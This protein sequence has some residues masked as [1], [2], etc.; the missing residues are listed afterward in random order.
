[1]QGG[2]STPVD[3]AR[4][5]ARVLTLLANPLHG[6]ILRAHAAG[7]LRAAE[8]K[9]MAGW[10]AQTTLRAANS[11]LRDYGLLARREVSE[12]PYGVATELTP[13]GHEVL[14]VAEVVARWL[15]KAQPPIAL[16][17][18]KAKTAVKSLAGGW[19]TKM[20]RE[21][22]FEPASLTDLDRRIP[23]VSYPSLERRLTRMR[24]TRQV[25]PSPAEGRGTPFEVTEW[26]RHSVP[27]I[28][29]AVRCE[30]RYMPEQS[31]MVTAVEIEAC[32]LLALPLIPL[33]ES[34]DGTCTLSVLP[35]AGENGET[36]PEPAGVDV[37]V[38]AGEIV[39][40]APEVDHR[41]PAYALGTPM[42]WLNA[43]IEGHFEGLRFGGKN[44]QL[45][46]DLVNG[47]HLSLFG[48]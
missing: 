12:M 45:T 8:L 43:V 19:N 32:F 25:T 33:P 27:P 24:D 11:T 20:V 13:A 3:G 31:A 21:L 36:E 23:E 42:A 4:A 37:T 29:A 30:R 28:C 44:P 14:F 9:E 16:D 39:G 17:S 2:A 15:G 40:C 35:E 6:R 10:P 26:L 22:A 34:A 48:E 7:P 47:L 5:G 38:E 18:T 41:A 1:M 46:A